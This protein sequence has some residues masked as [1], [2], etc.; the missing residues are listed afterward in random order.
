MWRQ[1]TRGLTWIYIVLM[2]GF[3]ERAVERIAV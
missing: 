2:M 1:R 3:S